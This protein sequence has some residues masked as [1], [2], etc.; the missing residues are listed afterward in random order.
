M[1]NVDNLVRTLG[2]LALVALY[3]VKWAVDTKDR[4]REDSNGGIKPMMRT[5]LKELDEHRVREERI[6]TEIC[7]AEKHQTEAIEKFIDRETVRWDKVADAI[8]RLRDTLQ[9]GIA[10]RFK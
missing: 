10:A 3:A 4:K 9:S 8:D 5:M 7:D 1:D 6:L 2:V